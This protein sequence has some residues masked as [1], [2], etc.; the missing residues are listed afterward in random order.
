MD[1]AEPNRFADPRCVAR[2]FCVCAVLLGV[3]LPRSFIP[4]RGRSQCPIAWWDRVGDWVHRDTLRLVIW[5]GTGLRCVYR[6][7][8]FRFV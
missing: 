7:L 5:N 2:C 4:A 1:L 8:L 3:R 6:S